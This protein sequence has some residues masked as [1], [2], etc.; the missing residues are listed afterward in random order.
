MAEN[1][2]LYAVARIRSRELRLLTSPFM[3]QLAA[4]PDEAACMRLLREKG[5]DGGAPEDSDGMLAEEQKKTWGLMQELVK[6]MSVFDV[7]LYVNDYHNL[8]AAI[9][10][11]KSKNPFTNIYLGQGTVPVED[12]QK[13]IRENDLSILPESMREP[14]EEGMKALLHTGD[15][16][17]CDMIIDRAALEAVRKAGESSGNEFLKLYGELTVAAADIKIAVRASRTGKNRT[18][19]ETALVECGTLNL[20]ALTEAALESEEAVAAYLEKTD[21]SDGALELRKSPSAFE[22]WCDNLLIRRIRPQLHNPFGI[23][24]LAAYIL[25]RD[26]EI[27]SVRIIL[28]GKRNGLPAEAIRERVRETYV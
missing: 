26:S 21:Y 3:E 2:Y 16:Q 11:C 5:W 22:R 14:A 4:A 1:Q 13:A 25:A 23:G 10:E 27:K 24:P 6:D 20:K 19:L 7:F 15:G 9:K 8:K 18:F 12:I 17:L 28:A